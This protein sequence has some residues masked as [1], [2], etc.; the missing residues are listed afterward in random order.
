MGKL[1][2][3]LISFG[4]LLGMACCIPVFTIAQDK[5]NLDTI[6]IQIVKE[7]APTI[8]DAFKKKKNPSVSDSL[9]FPTKISY[10]VRPEMIP[11]EF[12]LEPIPPAK[13]KGEP[14]IK[15]YKGYVKGGFGSQTTG[16]GEVF[17]NQ[18][19]SRKGSW[20]IHGKHLS[21]AGK[22]KDVGYSGYSDSR[23]NVYGKR[24]LRKHT[25]SG[26]IDYNRNVVHHY[27][28]DATGIA[29]DVL[30]Y[31]KEPTRQ[32]FGAITAS[33]RLLSHYRDSAMLNHDIRLRFTNLTD[34]F[35][36]A[37][38]NFV[39]M[40]KV[41][42]YL[43]SEF[44]NIDVSVDY[45]EDRF[46]KGTDSSL[47][48]T[49]TLVKISPSIST[50]GE[51]Y[52]FVVGINGM[53]DIDGS[54]GALYH[55]YPRVY[56]SYMLINEVMVGYC[57]I[58]GEIK[59]QNMRLISND[60]PFVV[61]MPNILN[62]DY[63]MKIFGGLKGEMSSSSSYNIS[64]NRSKIGNAGFYV[65]D[66]S[67][68]GNQ[69]IIVYDN[70]KYLN[71]RG[72]VSLFQRDKL[73]LHLL[74]QYNLYSMDREE[75]PWHTPQYELSVTGNYNLQDKIL[76]NAGVFAYG[77]QYAKEFGADGLTVKPLK[78]SGMVDI[79]VGFEYRYTKKLS[80]FLKLHN[81]ASVSYYKWNKYPLQRF[82]LLGGLT[83]VF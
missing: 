23:L 7:Y 13:I 43:N 42:R 30:D 2:K 62:R 45:N 12:D 79:N 54:D 27:G 71:I 69:F 81:L 44:L 33:G 63:Q 58:L 52:K 78:L 48:K 24:F 19:R 56:F 83:Y 3:Q 74:G 82:N 53:I 29:E 20:G 77:S 80:L 67:G 11:P 35:N 70:V 59:R 73:S 64:F 66:T 4:F 57:G 21:S 18:L 9:H 5:E 76:V 68:I 61:S 31:L 32:R 60:N 1:K 14:L 47:L 17:V 49:N 40:T 38:N 16:Y 28:F 26:G 37:E 34:L 25:L 10:S 72:E 46:N 51:K 41:N 15:L 6:S 39:L 22:I 65:N 50:S 36:M 8:S 55:F 75:H